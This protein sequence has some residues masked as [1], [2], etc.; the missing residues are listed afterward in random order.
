[1]LYYK[2]QVTYPNGEMEDLDEDFFT[3]N[4]A[5]ESAEHILGEVGYNASFH[6]SF[7]DE[8]GESKDVQPFAVVLEISDEGEKI[9]YD[10]REK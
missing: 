9:V 2:V 7:F 5:I 3:L 1:M 10:S 4:K 6:A 8:D